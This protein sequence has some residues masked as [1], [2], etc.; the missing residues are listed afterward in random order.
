MKDRGLRKQEFAD[1][2]FQNSYLDHGSCSKIFDY[3]ESI[4][5]EFELED[6]WAKSDTDYANTA[7]YYYVFHGLDF[8]VDCNL[9]W[10]DYDYFVKNI[11]NGLVEIPEVGTVFNIHFFKNLGGENDVCG[12]INTF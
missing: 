2:L 10:I 12:I 3:L 7:I 5:C 6:P 8:F 4:D 9:E 11:K 1:R